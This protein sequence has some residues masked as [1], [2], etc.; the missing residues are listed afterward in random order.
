[1]VV[2]HKTVWVVAVELVKLDKMLHQEMVEE[3]EQEDL[4]LLLDHA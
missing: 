3:V 4:T 2:H 1:M